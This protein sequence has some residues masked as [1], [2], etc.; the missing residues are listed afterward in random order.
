MN[1]V[2]GIFL[3]LV[4]IAFNA[5]FFQLQRTFDYPNI[6]RQPT[7]DVLTRFDQGGSRLRATWYA[8][9]LSAILFTPVPVLVLLVFGPDAPWH[10]VIGTVC[11]VIAAIMQFLGL[12]RWPFLVPG[13]ASRFVDPQS[14]PAT[15][16]SA[17][18]TFEAFHRY[19]GVAVGEHL[20]YIF[21][22]AWTLLVSFAI[23]ES[24][25]FPPVLGWLGIIPALGI[26]AGVLEEVGV[27]QAAIVNA[28]AYVLWSLWLIVLGIMLFWF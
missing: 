18:V 8:F 12:I 13:L 23:I 15:R 26:L 1:V 10:L 16:D 21:T 7:A 24:G 27:K 19:I 6:L 3:I 22:F 2:A 14:S 5:M 25:L 28:I 20:G 4:P 9:A 11:G 17:A